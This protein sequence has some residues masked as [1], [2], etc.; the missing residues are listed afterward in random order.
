MSYM[1]IAGAQASG[2][3]PLQHR[4]FERPNNGLEGWDVDYR[5]HKRCVRITGRRD[6]GGGI[7]HW[8]YDPESVGDL[9]LGLCWPND[10]G[11][12]RPIPGWSFGFGSVI[13]NQ[14]ARGTATRG[15]AG[16]SNRSR[17][18]MLARPVGD[19][20]YGQDGRFIPL[21][22]DPLVMRGKGP[23]PEPPGGGG[24]G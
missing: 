18:P 2:V 6:A 1:D 10:K 22:V 11:G 8:E 20:A 12:A 14:G 13:A 15:G 17:G 5:A 19:R 24:G 3:L 4:R 16:G 21:A 9:M 7:G 23:K